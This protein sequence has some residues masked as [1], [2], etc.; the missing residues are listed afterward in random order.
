MGYSE[1]LQLKYNYFPSLD[2]IIFEDGVCYT[3]REAIIVS[4]MKNPVDIRA[5][6]LC[7]QVFGGE[8]IHESDARESNHISWFEQSPPVTL[9]DPSPV[10]VTPDIKYRG[11][12]KKQIKPDAEVLTFF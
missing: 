6:H 8:I 4:R 3:M 9:P 11:H 1:A 5:A 7:K 10:P 2:Q 12:E